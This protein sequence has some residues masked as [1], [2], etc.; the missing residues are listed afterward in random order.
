VLTTREK[1]GGDEYPNAKT[2][3]QHLPVSELIFSHRPLCSGLVF[4]GGM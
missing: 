1:A 2:P 4:G 3:I